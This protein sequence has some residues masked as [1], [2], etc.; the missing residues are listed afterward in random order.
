[1][2]TQNTQVGP[3]A[4]YIGRVGALA[5]KGSYTEIDLMRAI[6]HAIDPANLMN[7]GRIL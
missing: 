3:Y 6:K 1:M 5:G 7:P 4:R 2:S